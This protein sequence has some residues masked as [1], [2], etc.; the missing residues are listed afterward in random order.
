M[1]YVSS[2]NQTNQKSRADCNSFLWKG[3][4]G[5]SVGAK[6]SWLQVCK[7]RDEGGLGLK[8]LSDWNKAHFARLVWM[9][10]RGTES[11]WIAWI[12]TIM[13][14]GKSFWSVNPDANSLWN[15]NKLL[16][17]R[18]LFRPMIKYK[19]G[20]GQMIHP[21]FDSWHPKGPMLEAYSHRLVIE[22]SLHLNSKLAVVIRDLSGYGEL[23]DLIIWWR[24]NL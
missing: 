9:I 2:S 15:W 18:P 16:K 21:W 4:A 24:C 12:H 14:K 5:T 19:V 11:L 23:L 20:N 7:P 22:S 3:E 1:L 17:V 13:F 6:V 8:N 10:S